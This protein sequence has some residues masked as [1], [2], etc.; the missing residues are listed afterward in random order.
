MNEVP[1]RDLTIR[2]QAEL[3]VKQEQGKKALVAMKKILTDRAA[4]AAVLAG[5]D[6]KIADLER[7]I[8]DGT[9]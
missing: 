2:E 5:F 4:A 3:E 7:Q 8:A 9:F 1:K 6:M